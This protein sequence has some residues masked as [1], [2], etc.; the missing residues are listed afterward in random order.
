M[1][2]GFIDML[3]FSSYK[4]TIIL[5]NGYRKNAQKLKSKVRV[6]T[7]QG[8]EEWGAEKRKRIL[9]IGNFG[10]TK[11]KTEEQ[12]REEIKKHKDWLRDNKFYENKR[13]VAWIKKR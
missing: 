2:L 6:R 13:S 12:I 5:K 7:G 10:G 9:H 11:V 8:K 4:T 3:V 1:L